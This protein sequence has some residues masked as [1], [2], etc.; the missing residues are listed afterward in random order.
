MFRHDPRICKKVQEVRKCS[1]I[2]PEALRCSRNFPH[3]SRRS[4]IRSFQMLT[5]AVLPSVMCSILSWSRDVPRISQEVP[6]APRRC[7]ELPDA[8]GCIHKLP[9]PTRSS[10][11]L[12]EA[13][14][15]SQMLPRAPSCSQK[16][17]VVPAVCLFNHK[18]FDSIVVDNFFQNL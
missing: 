2:L 13:C 18:V 5:E 8:R 17:P 10:Q 9:N 4:Y 6:A 16:V 1:Q 12:P 11:M 15:C 3:A 7:Q 14:T